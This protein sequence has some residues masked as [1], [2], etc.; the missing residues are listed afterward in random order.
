M[1]KQILY[2]LSVSVL[3]AGCGTASNEPANGAEDTKSEETAEQ[4][5]SAEQQEQDSMK[6]EKESEETKETAKPGTKSD[7]AKDKP[8]Q[9]A[10]KRESYLKK[11][12]DIEK[13][14]SEFDSALEGTTKEMTDATGE[15]FERWDGALN[16]IYGELSADLPADAMA[17]LR[18]EQREWIAYRDDTANKEALKYKGGSMETLVYMS[19]QAKLT[20][21][22]CYELVEGYM[23]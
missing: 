17:K 12:A 15:I 1:M 3:L 16:D 2:I 19:A 11:L 20:E 13:S 10:G 9:A 21:E 14:L 23:D 5:D 4:T 22:R 6:G 7:S 18:K 8:A